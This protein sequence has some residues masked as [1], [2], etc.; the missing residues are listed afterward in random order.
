MASKDE[1]V[2]GW[3]KQTRIA[4]SWMSGPRAKKLNALADEMDEV[5][6]VDSHPVQNPDQRAQG[7]AAD[8][9]AQAKTAKKTAAKKTAKKTAAKK[10][11]P[12]EEPGSV[13]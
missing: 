8:K 9:R 4:A 5:A 6:G 3:A 13:E 1:Q 2:N 12:K 10:A 11:A 7:Q